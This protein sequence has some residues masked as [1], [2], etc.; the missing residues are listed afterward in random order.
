MSNKFFRINSRTLEIVTYLRV[1]VIVVP[2]KL[3]TKE[4][5]FYLIEQKHQVKRNNKNNTVVFTMKYYLT[6][7]L[8]NFLHIPVKISHFVQN[9][10]YIT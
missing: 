7:L 5:L 8:Q 3:V 10:I 4:K 2:L 1:S 9:E 6:F